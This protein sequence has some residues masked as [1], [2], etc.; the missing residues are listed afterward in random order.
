[1]GLNLG[2]Q[3]GKSVQAA[4][5]AS[6]ARPS[7]PLRGARGRCRRSERSNVARRIGA[8][9]MLKQKLL[10]QATGPV[11]TIRQMQRKAN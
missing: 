2:L 3:V 11:G 7:S 1:M 8:A 10:Q 4:R 6:R 9:G 5:H